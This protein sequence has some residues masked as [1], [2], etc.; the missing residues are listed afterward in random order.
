MKIKDIEKCLKK[1]NDKVIVP[2]VLDTVKATPINRLLTGETPVQ[3]FKKQLAMQL[4]IITVGIVIVAFVAF[5][6]L[7]FVNPKDT[8][9][10][11]AY[12]SFNISGSE[13]LRY[14]MVIGADG[15]VKLLVKETTGE[16]L[17][18][19]TGY[20]LKSCIE[21]IYTPSSMDKVSFYVMCSKSDLGSYW[22]R[23][24]VNDVLSMCINGKEI[25]QVTSFQGKENELITYINSKVDESGKVSAATDADSIIALYLKLVRG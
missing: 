7:A 14:G 13:S 16:A 20:E 6:A 23:E 18:Q 24:A 2:D 21:S 15:T 12:C 25:S 1:E 19:Y 8:I 9:G 17:E 11:D 4:L 10:P 22:C 5:A 3:A